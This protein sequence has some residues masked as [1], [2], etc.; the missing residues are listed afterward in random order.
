MRFAKGHGT[1]ND[2]VILP[3]PDAELELSATFVAAVCDR[4]AGIGA[5]GVLHVVRTKLSAEVADQADEAEWFMDYRNA[6]GSLAEMCGN[7][8]RVF[9]RY[10]VDTGLA[11][12][13]EFGVATRAGVRRVRLEE[14]G[15]VSVDMGLPRVLGTSRTS[16]SGREYEGLHVDMGNP[17]LACV[18]GDPVA[19]LDLGRQ[20][21]FDPEV[22]PSGVNVE[23]LNPVGPR[24]IVMRVFE[25]GSGETRSCGTGTVASTV[26]AAH[27][28]GESTGTWTVEVP[29]GT[30]TVTLDERTSHLTG[31]AVLVASGE[32]DL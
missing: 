9:A 10:L 14:S 6:D 7:G 22:F 24:R 30:V 16:V 19:Q 25:R 26:A 12:A 15:D 32:L 21:V 13:G 31:P 3:D 11:G 1:E 28:A 17:H 2:F 29:G 20:P 27:L 23:L 18:I 8:I 4:R 5:D